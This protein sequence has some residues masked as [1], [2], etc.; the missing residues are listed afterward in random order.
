MLVALLRARGLSLLVECSAL[1]RSTREENHMLD[2]F[3][4]LPYGGSMR[5]K[6]VDAYLAAGWVGLLYVLTLLL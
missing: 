1:E 3:R 6:V 4:L 5:D 2:V